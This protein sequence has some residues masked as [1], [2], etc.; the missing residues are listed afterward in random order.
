MMVMSAAASMLAVMVMLMVMLVT[1]AAFM[2]VVSGDA[3]GDARGR[4]RIHARRGGDAHGD[5]RVHVHTQGILPLPIISS[6]RDTGCSITSTSFS[7]E[8]FSIGVVIIAAFY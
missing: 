7:P 2:L 8:S 3:H 5:A 1:A 6:S 4:S